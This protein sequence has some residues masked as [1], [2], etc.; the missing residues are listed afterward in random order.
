MGVTDVP[1]WLPAAFVRSVLAVG[2]T[3]PREEIESTCRRL[4]DR[5]Q[6]AD[7]HFHNL[8]HLI[9]V[10]ARVDELAEETHHPD[11]VRLAAWYH[12]A[13]F[14]SVARKAYSRS[15]GEDEEASAELA[16]A[17]LGAL[18]VPERVTARIGELI[19]NLKR[20]EASRRDID[21]LALCD[22]DLAVLASEPQKYQA[23]RKAVR[24]EYAHLP[25]RHYVEARTAIVTKL[26]NRRDI[27]V[28]PMGAQWED[29]ARENLSAELDRLHAEHARLGEAGPEDSVA[30]AEAAQGEITQEEPRADDGD[31][32][33]PHT[34]TSAP[35]SSLPGWAGHG[36]PSSAGNRAPRREGAAATAQGDEVGDDASATGQA[37]AEAPAGETPASEPAAGTRTSEPAGETRGSEPAFRSS[38]PATGTWTSGPA[39]GLPSSGR[40]ASRAAG[41]SSSLEALPEELDAPRRRGDDEATSD[42]EEI[43]RSSRGRIEAAVRLGRER[44]ERERRQRERLAAA[45]AER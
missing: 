43:A 38:E 6:A 12:G 11:T 33:V 13:V 45:R 2:A 25:A 19:L 5:W 22:A 23:Y 21:C 31:T 34:F 39:L 16:T 35:P 42:R 4:L 9:D 44:A 7:R 14:S 37:A 17:E 29:A 41:R 36:T 24:A 27:F 30:A 10:L 28:S 3:A 26:L 1:Q 15:G 18:G 20:H 32:S 8:R 40:A